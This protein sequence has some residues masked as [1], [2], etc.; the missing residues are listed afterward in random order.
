[1]LGGN[2]PQ[3]ALQRHRACYFLS[4]HN[5][6]LGGHTS[7]VGVTAPKCPRGAGLVNFKVLISSVRAPVQTS[8]DLWI[9]TFSI[10]SQTQTLLL[11]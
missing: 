8:I 7:P 3:N 4:G 9:P 10:V 11:S 5:P 6:H 2:R 1:M